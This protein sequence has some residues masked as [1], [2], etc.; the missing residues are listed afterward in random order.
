M[1]Q[2][3]Q[4]CIKYMCQT[5]PYRMLKDWSYEMTTDPLLTD[6]ENDVNNLENIAEDAIYELSQEICNKK[7]K[8]ARKKKNDKGDVSNI[9][10]SKTKYN[11]I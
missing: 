6:A 2:T 7:S 1:K 4:K 9:N 5:E 8:L 11:F 3:L 10:I